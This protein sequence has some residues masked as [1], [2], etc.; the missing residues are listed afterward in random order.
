M[1]WCIIVNDAPFLIEFLGKLSF[2]LLEQ[3]DECVLVYTS[4]IAEYTKTRHF[5][6]EAK[7][8]SGV[9]WC[10][11]HYDASPR[12]YGEL[13]WREL[14]P[15]FDRM[16]NWPWGY[17][18]SK[19]R[20]AQYYQFFDEFLQRE[21]PDAILF[22]LPSGGAAQ[23]AFFLSAKY[24]IPYLGIIES[25]I[26]GHIDVLDPGCHSALYQQTFNA[27]APENISADEAQFARHFIRGFLSH[28]LLPSYYGVGT[29]RFGLFEY[30]VHYFKRVREIG[31]PMWQ[32]FSRRKKFKDTDFETESRL[33][34]ALR[35]PGALALRQARIM[36]QKHLYERAESQ[37]EYYLFPLHVQ[38]EASTSAQAM[39]Y[40][41]QVSTIRNIAFSLPFPCKLYVKEHPYAVGSKPD[42]FY[43]AIKN[44]PNVRLI[45]PQENMQELIRH[46]QGVI[47][48]TG[49]VGMEAAMAGKPA[50]V[51]GNVFYDYHPLCRISKNM[52][53]LREQIL[54]DRK[55][56][57]PQENLQEQNIRFVVSYLRHTVPGNTVA[58]TIENDSNDYRAIAHDLRRVAQA[59]QRSFRV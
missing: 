24:G 13:T 25:R 44:I 8:I 29:I 9:D 21:Q 33:R 20:L 27:L 4:K 6:K 10:L 59:R 22:E 52:D 58:A 5:P 19:K 47:A 43:R 17:Q 35:A 23:P 15:D 56:G 34:T 45:A 38:P 41:N 57:V 50:Y 16:V 2:K 51:L 42:S 3:G 11:A 55:N 37:D 49:T 14:F 31:G 18:E 46:S 40:V 30:I 32:Y 7:A 26:A 1:K 28:E 48:L 39:Q 12:E 54:T 53:E 36:L